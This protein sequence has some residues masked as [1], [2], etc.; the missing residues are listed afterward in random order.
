MG[1]PKPIKFRTLGKITKDNLKLRPIVSTCGTFYYET[2]KFLASNLLPL[3]DNEYSIKTTTDFSE[4]TSNRTV[5][6]DDEVLVSYDVSSLF[7]EVPLDKPLTTSFMKSTPTISYHNL[8]RSY[9]L[10]AFSVMSPRTQFSVLMITCIDKLMD[11]AWATHYLQSLQTFS[12][13]N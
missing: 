4:R 13:P 9:S 2:A 5:D 10:D 1:L 12:W 7:T 11:A 6:D 3:T 8:V